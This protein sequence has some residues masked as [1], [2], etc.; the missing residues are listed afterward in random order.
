[1]F[2]GSAQ[3]HTRKNKQGRDN[4]LGR[5]CANRARLRRKAPARQ[6]S[7]THKGSK[8]KSPFCVVLKIYHL[9][10]WI[11]HKTCLKHSNFLN[12]KI[13][14]TW[15]IMAT[16]M[17]QG[18]EET[19]RVETRFKIQQFQQS[20][21]RKVCWT[22]SQTRPW[23]FGSRFFSSLSRSCCRGAAHRHARMFLT[24]GLS[25]CHCSE[26]RSVIELCLSR[27]TFALDFVLHLFSLHHFSSVS[28][29][30]APHRNE[31]STPPATSRQDSRRKTETAHADTP[32]TDKKQQQRQHTALRNKTEQHSSS[33]TKRKKINNCRP[34]TNNNN[35]QPHTTRATHDTT[36]HTT[37]TA[38][39]PPPSTHTQTKP[40]TTSHH[41]ANMR[42]AL[43][44]HSPAAT[45]TRSC[46][47]TAPE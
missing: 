24:T 21:C 23:L 31:A 34:A 47:F 28:L 18:T 30:I 2:N 8:T 29:S 13:L 45:S 10:T 43:T 16:A 11:L 44:K 6:Q 15:N 3:V 40:P 32:M 20:M 12:R 42:A 39:F 37:N 22:T 36:P 1:M 26:M 38:P 4:T 5:H 41:P 27:L 17:G 33:I 9:N 46:T 35:E 25:N 7:T 14:C 19:Q